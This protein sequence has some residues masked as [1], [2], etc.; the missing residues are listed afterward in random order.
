MDSSDSLAGQVRQAL[1]GLSA[2]AQEVVQLHYFSGLSYD[3][4]A[5]ALGISSQ[6]VH[7]RMQ[8]ARQMLARRLSATSE[9]G[10]LENQIR[11]IRE[12]ITS[13]E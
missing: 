13:D 7:G 6:A 10:H 2:S 4:I 5:R 12:G 11:G 1:E 9:E 3:Q 8:R